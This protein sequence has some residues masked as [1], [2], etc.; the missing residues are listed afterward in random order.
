MVCDLIKG[1][2]L[3]CCELV[4]GFKVVYFVDFGDLGNIILFLD[5][6]MDMDGIFFVY[7]YELKG[8][9]SVE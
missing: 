3:F 6:I 2:V 9:L 7:K 5:E 1:C 8:I 4:G